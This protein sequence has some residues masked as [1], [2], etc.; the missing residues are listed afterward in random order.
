MS[1]H[2]LPSPFDGKEIWFLTGSQDLYGEE[3]L[4]RVAE[5]SRRVAA[6]LDEAEAVPVP[7]V[8]KP[9]LK[10]RD[11]IRAAMLAANA[12]DACIG[13]IAW[14]HTFSPAKMW[15]AGIDALAEPLLQL[16]TQY[17]ESLP[18]STID[19]DYMNLNQ[20]AHGDREFGY[21]LTRLGRPRK[22]VVGHATHAATR[23]KV[24]VWARAAAGWD[25]LHRTRLVRFGDN[26]RNV[27]VTEGDKTEAELR[28]GASVNTWGVNDLVA[29]VDAVG[30]GEIDALVAEYLEAYD[31]VPELAPGGARH[32]SLRYGARLE[33]GMRRFLESRGATA[34]TTNFE[35]LGGLRQ[36]PGLAVQRLMADGYGFGAEGDWKT[37][38][39]VRAAKVMGHGLSGGASLM[40][41]Y[42]YEMTPG[43]EKILGAHMLEVCPSLTESRPRL[44]IHPLGIGG[45]EDP[46]RLVFDADPGPG[47]VVA[48][49]DLRER[50]RLTANVVSVVG[51]D[52]PL[53]KLPVARAVW[54]PAPDFATSTECW[55]L[56]GAAHHTVMDTASGPEA[57]ADLA[58]IARMELAVID[59]GTTTRDFARTL[60]LNQ[61]YHR[62]AQGA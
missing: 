11:A 41:D 10:D 57:W 40:E 4:A 33:A 20:A 21:L 2:A 17:S 14:M 47:L 25:A 8:W 29:V 51:P 9:V 37:A 24:G 44:E 46:V 60:R 30:T 36:L 59:E 1:A 13:V 6:W 53:P 23:A 3:T 5:Q 42:C 27:A 18:W 12:D 34:F 15:I 54:E 43:R 39:L 32:D 45:R 56:A 31:V 22:V 19:M 52:E 38:L 28:L 16:H 55:M 58:E 49:S 48:M 35:D 62:L 50:F 26:M 7:I 61:V